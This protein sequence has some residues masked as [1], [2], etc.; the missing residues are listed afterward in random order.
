MGS[1]NFSAIGSLKVA[2]M[3]FKVAISR[4]EESRRLRIIS[5]KWSASEISISPR[6]SRIGSVG[7]LM[8]R[9]KPSFKIIGP[10]NAKFNT[11]L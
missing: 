7:R 8:K 9:F 3:R 2:E 10:G 6:N 4:R 5:W 1:V 11:V